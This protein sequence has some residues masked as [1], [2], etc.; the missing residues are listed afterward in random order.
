MAEVSPTIFLG[1]PALFGLMLRRILDR[2]ESEGRGPQLRAAMRLVERIKTAT[3]INIGPLLFRNTIHRRLGGNLRFLASGSAALP[4]EVAR[5]YFQ[6]GLL[7]LQ[8][9]GMSE[10][11]P[12]IAVQEASRFKFLFTRF[13]EEQLGTVG[14][15]VDGLRVRLADAPEKHITVAERGEGEIVVCG[16]NVMAGYFRNEQATRGVVTIEGDDRWLRTGDLGRIDARG[17]LYITGRAKDVIVLASGEKVYPDEVEEK[18]LE[19]ELVEEVAVVDRLIDQDTRQTGPAAGKPA[20]EA[21]G[22]VQACA[23]VFPRFDALRA[24][25][26]REGRALTPEL[27][28]EWVIADLRRHEQD[29]APFK[30]MSEVFLVDSPLPKTPMRK[31]KR[32]E[33]SKALRAGLPQFSAERLEANSAATVLATPAA[34]SV[35]RA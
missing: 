26:E 23:V 1:V 5:Q 27:I 18:L 12:V 8:G 28:R 31:V 30:R 25:A 4:P 3:G 34:Q 22:R 29:V 15:P 24:M 13:Y 16:P 35:G 10:T 6:L 11:A 2:A 7:M 20:A 17:N 21:L 14:P 9:Y 33:V 32:F 19:S